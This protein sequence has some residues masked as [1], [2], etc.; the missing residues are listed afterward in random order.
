MHVAFVNKYYYPPHLGGVEQSLNLLARSLASR[1]HAVDAIV[2]NEGAR[3]LRETLDDVRVNRLA[4]TFAFA[5]TPIAPG[6]RAEIRRL[7]APG[8]ADVF[9]LQ[10]PY[11]WGE[12][13][14]LTAGVDTPTVLTYHADVV[15]QKRMMAAYAPALRRVL[16]RVDRVIVGAP[17]LVEHSPFLAPVAEKCRIVPFA[18]EYGRFEPVEEVEARVAAERASIEGPVVLF[19]GRLVYYKG[20]HVLVEALRDVRATLVVIGRGPEEPA[21]RERAVALGVADR[22]R[23]MPPVSDAELGAWYRAADVFCLPSTERTEAYGLVQLEAHQAGTPVVSTALPTGVPFVNLHDVSGLVVPPG[24][25][26]ALASALETLVTDDALRARL[27]ASAK[28]R[29]FS[30]FSIAAMVERTLDVYRE[31]MQLHAGDQ[32]SSERS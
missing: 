28:E 17:Q 12:M 5:S 22:I 2:A 32:T 9:H 10:F 11:P 13:A 16:E 30:E 14:W 3:E 15:R 26:S 31:A 1:G 25:A 8:A 24:D 19:V 23:W 4:R 29:A 20:V 21:L 18:I 27:G 7:A 6:M